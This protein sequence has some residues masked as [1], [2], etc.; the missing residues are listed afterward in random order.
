MRKVLIKSGMLTTL[1]ILLMAYSNP[2]PRMI[3]HKPLAKTDSVYAPSY[4]SM[5]N[6]VFQDGEEVV[7]QVFY[8]WKFV[9]LSAGEVTF[10][11]KEKKDQYHLSVIGTTYPSYEWFYKVEDKYDTYID[12]ETLLPDTSIRN[13][14]EG[15]YHLYDK[16]VFDR[17]RNVAKSLRGKTKETAEFN[18]YEVE[19][20]M[21][22]ILSIIYFSRNLEFDKMKEGADIPIKIFIDKETWPLRVRYLGKD[23]KKRIRGMGKYKTIMFSPQV[24][25]GYYFDDDTDMRV[26][27]SDDKNRIPLLIETPI[28]VGSI[29]AVLKE[30]KGLRYDFEAEL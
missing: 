6:N 24:I 9:W 25:S 28:S 20:C 7:Y 13:I 16:I 4:C 27:V 5:K 10:R 21:H 19:D 23:S 26:W 30:Y 15:K 3:K 2:E 1:G 14:Q 17:N 8:N 22:D 11:V 18:E 12:K 29:K